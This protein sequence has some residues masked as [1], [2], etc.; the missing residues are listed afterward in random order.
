MIKDF[1]FAYSSPHILKWSFWWA[2]AT[3]GYMQAGNYIQPLWE[4]IIPLE[5]DKERY[6]GVVEALTTSLGDLG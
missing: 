6:N 4:E 2:M 5:E 1:V 3:A